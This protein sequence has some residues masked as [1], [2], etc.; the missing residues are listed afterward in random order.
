MINWNPTTH[1]YQQN[2][3]FFG[4]GNLSFFALT[5][6]AFLRKFLQ[7]A[8]R[9]GRYVVNAE[10]YASASLSCL[11]YLT[12]CRLREPIN[13][14]HIQRN[15]V[16]R[17]KSPWHWRQHM[18]FIARQPILENFRYKGFP[19]KRYYRPFP[20]ECLFWKTFKH[21]DEQAKRRKIYLDSTHLALV[22]LGRAL[23]RSA[24]SD[25]LVTFVSAEKPF[26]QG[27]LQFPAKL[28]KCKAAIAT[29]L[30]RVQQQSGAQSGT[31]GA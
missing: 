6:S 3:I 23:P 25:E 21:L 5:S 26:T 9:S 20:L 14:H 2:M 28:K 30:A 19:E 4:G 1:W 7:D 15:L 17:Q 11:K 10:A 24:K 12:G 18:K 27:A 8:S 16:R 29:Y 22:F 13:F 31:T